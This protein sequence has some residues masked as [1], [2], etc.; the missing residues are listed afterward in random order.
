MPKVS[1]PMW[2]NRPIAKDEDAS[3]L[4]IR[5]ATYEFKHRMKR[6][7]AEHRAH[8]EYKQDKHREA[9]AFHLQGLKAAQHAGSQEEGHKHGLMYQLHMKALGLDPMDA[10]PH[11]IQSLADKQDKFYKFK[12]HRSDLFL[13]QS[14]GEADTQKSEG[15]AMGDDGE[16]LSKGDVVPFPGN[17][18]PAQDQGKAAPVKDLYAQVQCPD[19]I[20]GAHTALQTGGIEQAIGPRSAAIFAQK[21]PNVTNPNSYKV[22]DAHSRVAAHQTLAALMHARHGFKPK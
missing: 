8:H 13:L 20:N 22:A 7:D 4:D 1:S 15:G 16:G 19:C 12:P 3:D 6:E 5:S 14:Q 9:A 10:V 18:A 2:N 11:E 21:Y 17:K